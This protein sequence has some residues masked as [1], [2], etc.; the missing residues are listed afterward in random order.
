MEYAQ[1]RV[2]GLMREAGMQT[3]PGFVGRGWLWVLQK[4]KGNGKG[5]SLMR[6]LDLRFMRQDAKLLPEM[7]FYFLAVVFS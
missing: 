3:V 7:L 2:V 5:R 6:V 1:G 4:G